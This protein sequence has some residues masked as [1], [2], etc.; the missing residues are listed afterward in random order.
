M[1]FLATHEKNE[2]FKA[3]PKIL[4]HQYRKYKKKHKVL[5]VKRDILT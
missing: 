3:S 1:T 4:S 5:V 2:T